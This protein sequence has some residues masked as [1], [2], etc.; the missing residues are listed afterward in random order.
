MRH[1]GH[2]GAHSFELPSN[3][4]P[5]AFQLFS[6][7]S[8]S[9]SAT[10][11]HSFGGGRDHT[12]RFD[13][14]RPTEIRSRQLV[15]SNCDSDDIR[16]VYLRGGRHVYLRGDQHGDPAIPRG[17]LGVCRAYLLFALAVV[18]GAIRFDGRRI[19]RYYA[20]IVHISEERVFR[21]GSEP[22]VDRTGDGKQ[23]FHFYSRAWDPPCYPGDGRNTLTPDHTIW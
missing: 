20:N 19:Y 1:S 21:P 16:H 23:L 7:A 2:I 4:F 14:C 15:G 22:A 13:I 10:F 18:R 8:N 3:T 5:V 12:D 9:L 17:G 11:Y 6:N